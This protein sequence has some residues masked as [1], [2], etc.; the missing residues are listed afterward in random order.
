MKLHSPPFFLTGI[1]LPT[2]ESG[3]KYFITGITDALLEPFARS[4]AAYLLQTTCAVQLGNAASIFVSIQTCCF[5]EL[6]FQ[7]F[8]QTRGKKRGEKKLSDFF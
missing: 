6:D 7:C 1:L 8:P 4:G 3:C 2:S 5:L